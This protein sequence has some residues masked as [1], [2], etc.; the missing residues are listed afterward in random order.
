[1]NLIDAVVTNVIGIKYDDYGS[2]KYRWWVH[3]EYRDIG[4]T[5][6]EEIMCNSKEEAENISPGYK[7]LH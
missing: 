1:M 6:E 2:G 7:F 5:G 4:G 3:V